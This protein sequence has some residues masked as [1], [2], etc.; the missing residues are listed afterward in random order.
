ARIDRT[1]SGTRLSKQAGS[2]LAWRFRALGRPVA[3]GLLDH[4]QFL[5]NL[6]KRLNRPIQLLRRVRGRKLYTD[7]RLA[8]RDDGEAEA[9]D[10]DAM[11]QQLVGHLAGQSGVADHDRQDRVVA[12]LD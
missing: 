1:V 4:A 10:V 11:L 6:G 9:D 3:S 12:G 7:A 5:A 8:L 2:K